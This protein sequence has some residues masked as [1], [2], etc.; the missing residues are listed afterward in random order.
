MD[1]NS[2]TCRI[3]QVWCLLALVLLI[4]AVPIAPVRVAYAATTRFVAKNGADTGNCSV[5]SCLTIIYAIGQSVAG[6]TIMIG[7]G[8]YNEQSALVI[9]KNLTLTGTDAATTIV[10]RGGMGQIVFISSSATSVVISGLT[11]RN[12]YTNNSSGGAGIINYGGLSIDDS[13]VGDSRG[14]VCPGGGIRNANGATLTLNNTLIA[15]NSTIGATLGGGIYNTGALILNDSIVSGNTAGGE[16]GGIFNDSPGVITMTNSTVSRNTAEF[17]GGGIASRGGVVSM[18]NSTIS[19]NTA[20]GAGGGLR[21]TLG[22]RALIRN[23]TFSGSAANSD[24]SGAIAVSSSS[25]LSLESSTIAGNRASGGGAPYAG[26]ISNL[27]TATITNTIIAGNTARFEKDCDG[28]F[29]SGGYNLIGDSGD[30][31]VLSSAPGDQIGTTDNPIDPRLGPLQDNGGPSLTHA[32]LAGSP[33]RDKGS[34]ATPGS[35]AGAC[36]ASDQRI[37]ARTLGGRCDVGAYEF[38]GIPNLVNLHLGQPTPG[39]VDSRGPVAQFRQ[40]AGMAVN[41]A[42]AIAVVADSSNHII[43]KVVIATGDA[44]TIAGRRGLPGSSNGI[45]STAQFSQ[46]LGIALNTAGTFA[47]VADTGNHTIRRVDVASGQVTTLAG[48]A[49]APGSTN[50]T[51]SAARFNQPTG[52]AISSD[53]SFALIGDSGNDA[54]RKL[55]IATG[56]VSTVASPLAFT[57]IG[58]AQ[59]GGRRMIVPSNTDGCSVLVADNADHTIRQV[60]LSTGAVSPVAGSPGLAGASNGVGAAARFDAPA[61]VVLLGAG[62][63]LVADTNNHTIRRIDT[64][65]TPACTVPR[66]YL[67]MLRR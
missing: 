40:P 63:A 33:A 17:N 64:I 29:T 35:G 66:A 65:Q 45:S 34:P 36:P 59:S 1:L 11:L 28:A 18:S 23:S 44:I 3:Y 58:I 50:G 27:G 16:G 43:R 13:I 6:D 48:L 37:V 67:P 57:R 39:S 19:G 62:I 12:G 60:R 8:V 24:N 10:D 2:P 15:N 5:T 25:V 14:E 9:N 31:C 54:L 56:Q 21:L 51:G 46:P 61:G 32:L 55:V 4:A 53:G 7:P 26:G 52:I 47:L 49:G 41:G 38:S 30:T 42:G 22:A 20:G